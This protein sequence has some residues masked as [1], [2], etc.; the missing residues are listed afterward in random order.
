MPGLIGGIG[1]LIAGIAGFGSM[2]SQQSANK[3]NEQLTREMWAR[4]DK[5]VQRR[6]EDLK[7]AGLSPV[8]AAG[9]GASTSQPIPVKGVS[10]ELGG[11]AQ[12]AGL[13]QL[14]KIDSEVNMNNAQA[15]ALKNQS[16]ASRTQANL[17]VSRKQFQDLD[18]QAYRAGT[19]P[20][21]SD[22]REIINSILRDGQKTK[23][24]KFD[25][26]N[27]KIPTK[28]AVKNIQSPVL[29]ALKDQVK[30]Y[31]KMRGR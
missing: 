5:A 13:A 28:K 29:D 15:E 23:T 1:A 26:P 24:F 30:Q 2:A 16:L 21:G 8:L 31:N 17:N 9:Q 20:G 12:L 11:V 6:V 25:S 14:A 18:N 27:K 22:I 19:R 3:T 10:N 4:D 7:A